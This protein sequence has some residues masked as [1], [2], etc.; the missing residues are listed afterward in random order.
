MGIELSQKKWHIAFGN[1]QKI[2]HIVIESNDLCGLSQSIHEAQEKLC[3][4]KPCEVVSC[5]EAG[6]DGFWLHRHLK[7]I[8][9]KNYVVDSS[10]IAVDRK[11]KQRKTDR[12]DA[13]LLLQQLILH[14]VG[15]WRFRV[16]REPSVEEE[17]LRRLTRNYERLQSERK[18]HI[19]RIKSLLALQGIKYEEKSGRES[20]E[21][22]L[23]R[24]RNGLGESIPRYLLKEL[25]D[26]VE[27]LTLVEKQYNAVKK[28]LHDLSTIENKEV[29]EK[30][31]RLRRLKGIGDIGSC[32]LVLEMF[33]WRKFNNRREVGAASGLVGC[34]FASGSVSKE[35]GISKAGNGRVRAIMNQLAWL[36][37]RHQSRSSLSLWY[38]ERGFNKSARQKKIGIVALSRKLLIGLWR[39]VE[40]G[41]LPED[42]ELA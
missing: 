39:Y 5:Y 28:E 36:W 10:S 14:E 1:G 37:R 22:Y 18:G 20:W 31:I 38:D 6:R 30:I 23:F 13:K 34:P 42:W 21:H 25:L 2:R 33:G 9:V 4:G 3:L 19:C 17:D 27:R 41:V 11:A 32:I 26:E 35:Q 40:H 16:V 24:V 8:G 12:L 15:Q 29:K 7:S